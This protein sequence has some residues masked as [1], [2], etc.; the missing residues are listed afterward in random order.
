MITSYH[1]NAWSRQQNCAWFETP[2]SL[3]HITVMRFVIIITPVWLMLGSPIW[4]IFTLPAVRNNSGLRSA[5]GFNVWV[6]GWWRWLIKALIPEITN[7]TLWAR[8]QGEN[9]NISDLVYLLSS[10]TVLICD[11]RA[12][13]WCDISN[14]LL[15]ICRYPH[16]YKLER[17]QSELSAKGFHNPWRE[18]YYEYICHWKLEVYFSYWPMLRV[19]MPWWHST[20]QSAFEKADSPKTEIL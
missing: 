13:V 17:L 10:H 3:L 8:A 5:R 15:H 9:D 16:H 20:R 12:K 6:L 18:N 4:R 7:F 14:T 1:K 19:L 2:S 11:I